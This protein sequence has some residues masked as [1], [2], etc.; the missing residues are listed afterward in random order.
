MQQLMANTGDPDLIAL[1]TRSGLIHEGF[2][3]GYFATGD[4][5][6]AMVDLFE[7]SVAQLK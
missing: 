7:Q 2:A 6:Q 1:H 5:V 4:S 3:W